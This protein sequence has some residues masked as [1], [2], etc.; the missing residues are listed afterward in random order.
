M[1][2]RALLA[3]LATIAA[4]TIVTVVFGWGW[5]VTAVGIVVA[6]VAARIAVPTPR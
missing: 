2:G 4:G 1:I 5:W 3:I 6:V